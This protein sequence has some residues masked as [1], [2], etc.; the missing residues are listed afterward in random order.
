MLKN[1]FVTTPNAQLPTPKQRRIE[2]G[3]EV[4]S[5]DRS[6][7]GSWELRGGGEVGS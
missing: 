1:V 6:A 3:G 5:P 7:F 2:R 4:A